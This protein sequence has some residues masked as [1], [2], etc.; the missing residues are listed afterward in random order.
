LTVERPALQP[1]ETLT[2]SI[3]E[4]APLGAPHRH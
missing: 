4:G 1:G 3:G 2:V